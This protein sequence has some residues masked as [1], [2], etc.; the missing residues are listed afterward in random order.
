MMMMMMMMMMML[1]DVPVS[2]LVEALQLC[3]LT[4]S[5]S[6]RLR[7]MSYFDF[8]SR[9]INNEHIANVT[10]DKLSRSQVSFTHGLLLSTLPV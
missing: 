10:C 7:V 2:R 9:V 8:L 5:E 1:T 4:L 6:T 3:S